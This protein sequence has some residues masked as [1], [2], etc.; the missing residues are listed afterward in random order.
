[1]SWKTPCGLQ[2]TPPPPPVW[3]TSPP[4]VK[5]CT[6]T[7]IGRKD[8]R[9]RPTVAWLDS[10][11]LFWFGSSRHA[12][13]A[14][15]HP[16]R[17]AAPT[18]TWRLPFTVRLDLPVPVVSF[19]ANTATRAEPALTVRL[20]VTT[21]RPALTKHTPRTT[22]VA[23]VPLSVPGAVGVPEQV[24]VPLVTAAPAAVTGPAASRP[25][26]TALVNT[27]QDKLRR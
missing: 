4:I 7:P 19:S 1:M 8:R 9:S 24:V 12:K 18:L 3:I 23:C 25:P 10:V 13:F 15:L 27:R 21:A 17:R 16:M 20:P 2:L 14:G 22:T 11:G 6:M 5:L 26:T